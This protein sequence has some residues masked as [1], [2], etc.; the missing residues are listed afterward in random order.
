MNI[1][2]AD[3]EYWDAANSKFFYL[4]QDFT[5]TQFCEP[6]VTYEYA[7]IAESETGRSGNPNDANWHTWHN[8]SPDVY[9]QGDACSPGG[10]TVSVTLE[11]CPP[12]PCLENLDIKICTESKYSY[13]LGELFDCIPLRS[14]GEQVGFRLQLVSS[15]A[16]VGDAAVTYSEGDWTLTFDTY[17]INFGTV[18]AGP[19]DCA[20]QWKLIVD[21]TSCQGEYT[22]CVNITLEECGCPCPD[23]EKDYTICDVNYDNA[24]YVADSLLTTIHQIPFSLGREG[25]QTL[26]KGQPYMVSKGKIGYE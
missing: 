19:H 1:Q 23:D 21:E 8:D 2:G 22:A 6:G 25:G 3:N 14:D 26:R 5:V 11:N 7:V 12:T 16:W 20:I 18:G 24:E 17:D 15:A 9:D 10:T 13:D 4:D